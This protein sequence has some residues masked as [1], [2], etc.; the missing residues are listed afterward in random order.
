MDSFLDMLVSHY[1]G[2][3][4]GYQLWVCW[5]HPLSQM[6]DVYKSVCNICR[7]WKEMA[8]QSLHLTQ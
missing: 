6:Q 7:C 8:L 1:L 4:A 2:G 3:S 5:C